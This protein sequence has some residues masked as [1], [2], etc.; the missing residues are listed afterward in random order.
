MGVDED[1]AMDYLR[2]HAVLDA[3]QSSGSETAVVGDSFVGFFGRL[4][5]TVQ[6][7]SRT[8]LLG[9][10]VLLSLSGVALHAEPY[11]ANDPRIVPPRRISGAYPPYPGEARDQCVSGVVKLLLHV[12]KDGSIGGAEILEDAHFGMAELAKETVSTWIYEPG[13]LRSSKGPIEVLLPLTIRF[14]NPCP[15]PDNRPVRIGDEIAAPRKTSSPPPIYTDV[16]RRA[17]IQ[18][19]VI[20]EAIINKT[21]AVD[22]VRILKNLPG[23]LGEAARAAVKNWRFE[24]AVVKGE[25]INVFYTLTVNFNMDGN[26]EQAPNLVVRLLE[27]HPPQ[28]IG[29]VGEV[30]ANL[31]IR[32]NGKVADVKIIETSDVRLNQ[33]AREALYKWRYEAPKHP[34]SGRKTGAAVTVTLRFSGE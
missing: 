13:V 12:N 34:K 14:E 8:L 31:S 20:L 10:W 1:R 23:G 6:A 18:G 30:T 17:C 27:H 25:P 4:F 15:D 29:V 3:P 21:G 2:H 16:A 7:L 28:E 11:E 26:C 9:S 19:L 32:R 22:S 24:P 5:G 33:P